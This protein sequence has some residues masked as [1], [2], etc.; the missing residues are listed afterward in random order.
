M[1][2]SVTANVDPK[3]DPQTAKP[4]PTQAAGPKETANKAEAERLATKISSAKQALET[5]DGALAAPAPTPSINPFSPSKMSLSLISPS[6]SVQKN[7]LLNNGES[8]D[9][10][11]HDNPT[12]TS[13]PHESESA[14][15]LDPVRHLT[16]LMSQLYDASAY[17]SAF[18][19]T[20][21]ASVKSDHAATIQRDSPLTTQ[22]GSSSPSLTI[23]I[24]SV[25]VAENPVNTS[26]QMSVTTK[27]TPITMPNKNGTPS[28]TRNLEKSAATSNPSSSLGVL[29]NSGT[30]VNPASDLSDYRTPIDVLDET[31]TAQQ[32][33]AQPTDTP[34][35]SETSA[36]SKNDGSAT[37]PQSEPETELEPHGSVNSSPSPQQDNSNA[38]DKTNAVDTAK[39]TP[40]PSSQ[41]Y[42]NDSLA[43][44]NTASV[45]EA[46]PVPFFQKDKHNALGNVNDGKT[47]DN[48]SLPLAQ[49]HE[50]DVLGETN[51]AGGPY[52]LPSS[53]Q[54]HTSARRETPTHASEVILLPSAQQGKN[55][56]HAK[57]TAT[58]SGKTGPLTSSK[59]ANL[60]TPHT[61]NTSRVTETSPL[62]SSRQNDT[63]TFE[64][65]NGP[66]TAE[67]NPLPF[68][69][70]A[71]NNILNSNDTT[72]VTDTSPLP[73][74]QQTSIKALEAKDTTDTAGM[75]TVFL[76][77]SPPLSPSVPSPLSSS[78]SETT[79]VVSSEAPKNENS[80]EPT[81]AGNTKGSGVLTARTGAAFLI[82]LITLYLSL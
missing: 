46:S 28:I 54:S 49:N 2:P 12:R 18:R 57:A 5:N 81:S 76:A 66:D 61:T 58:H 35:P 56:A 71:N 53:L 8:E 63:N 41:G 52:P 16:G 64:N 62:P 31:I 48:T 45:T 51:A 79:S 65:S 47:T 73:F 21:K 72:V 11:H 3:L 43:A 9:Q 20:S 19:Q 1:V 37:A 7:V 78:S 10:E 39:T 17:N 14:A 75:S 6:S 67:N 59:Q 77:S 74:S 29:F 44:M 38:L 42:D 25:P 80:D 82:L 68:P 26:N 4:S 40:L 33:S 32:A 15:F 24:P 50:N 13:N 36:R 60:N 69:Q 27:G 23:A 70:Q 22:H 30:N 55:Y 34:I